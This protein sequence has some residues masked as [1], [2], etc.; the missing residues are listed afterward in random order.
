LWM[1]RAVAIVLAAITPLFI[2]ILILIIFSDLEVIFKMLTQFQYDYGRLLGIAINLFIVET[3]MR[4]KQL[5]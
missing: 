2:D 3:I 1:A 5:K 4:K